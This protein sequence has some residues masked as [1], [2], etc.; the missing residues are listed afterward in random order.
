MSQCFNKQEPIL[1]SEEPKEELVH[2]HFLDAWKKCLPWKSEKHFTVSLCSDASNSG[3]GGI[4][5]LLAD[6]KESHD[7]WKNDELACSTAVKEAKA[8]QH[9]LMVFS[10]EI[11]NGRVNALVD[12]KNLIDGGNKEG[13]RSISLTN[14]VK[15][16]FH[17]CFNLDINLILAHVPLQQMEADAPSRY[18]YDIECRLSDQ[19]WEIVDSAFGHHTIDLMALP[20]N[21]R[22]DRSGQP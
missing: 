14:E 5:S 21:V 22:T 18:T 19:L 15:R 6:K 16:L 4:L 11:Q 20:S 7:Y 17:L 13:S 12:N 9:T 3:W 2:W 10:N 8:L 1:V